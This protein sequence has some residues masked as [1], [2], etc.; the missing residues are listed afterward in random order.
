M[1]KS[2][3]RNRV[4]YF[5]GAGFSKAFGL[6]NTAELLSEVHALS[7]ENPHWGVSRDIPARLEAA[8]RYF[9]PDEG[10]NFRPPVGD[11]F[12][13]LATYGEVAGAGLPQGFPD[14]KLLDDLKFAITNIL[15]S[16]MKLI[17][18]QLKNSHGFLDELV[19]P[20]NVVITSN[21][22]YLIERSCSR[23]GVPYRLRWYQDEST[24]TVLKLH[25]SVDWTKKENAKLAWS[26]N[27]YYR[28]EDII[29][30]SRERHDHLRGKHVA[31]CHATENWTRAYQ[32][33]KATTKRPFMLT[34]ARGKADSIRPL[35]DI[36]NDAY[37]VLSRARELRIVG[38]S[39]PD[40][41]VEI[42]TLLRAGV[43]RGTRNPGVFVVNP[44]P[45]VHVRIR[46]QILGRIS[47]DYSSV[48]G[49]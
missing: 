24:V 49:L 42:R 16:R 41:D 19:R 4:V 12:T 33:I 22:D 31:R 29:G 6:P 20:G 44:A 25:G 8:Y 5:L 37:D 9:Y 15:C 46:Q 2:P 43:C 17:D 47:S 10:R 35:L 18:K 30:G 36:W 38:Y 13:V 28:L 39:M 7:V 11:F 1:S 45:D 3:D 34:M 21:W 23:R 32:K 14:S 27:N 26:T 40:D 48:P